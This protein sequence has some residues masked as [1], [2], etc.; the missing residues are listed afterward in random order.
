MFYLNIQAKAFSSIKL[1]K[2]SGTKIHPILNY[3][4]KL[5]KFYFVIKFFHSQR[6]CLFVCFDIVA[7]IV[8]ASIY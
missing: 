1:K 7:N 6:Y 8:N 4:L 5:Q 2:G 3:T